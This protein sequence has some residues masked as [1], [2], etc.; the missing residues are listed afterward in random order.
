MITAPNLQASGEFLERY[1]LIVQ[2]CMDWLESS[3]ELTTD[4]DRKINLE[5]IQEALSPW[6]LSPTDNKIIICAY[7]CK[8]L[9]CSNAVLFLE[10]VRQ[11][12]FTQHRM[13]RNLTDCLS[14]LIQAQYLHNDFT[15][16]INN[17]NE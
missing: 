2:K 7:H 3:K 8:Q 13:D 16:A 17:L 9:V 15:N 5:F 12:G 1:I 4:K 6:E 14:Y 11:Y 10:G